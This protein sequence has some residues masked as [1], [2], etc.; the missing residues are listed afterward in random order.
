MYD[1]ALH[2]ELPPMN[3][4]ASVSVFDNQYMLL[5]SIAKEKNTIDILHTQA[6]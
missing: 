1:S 2:T 3:R 4:V 5:K 6:S